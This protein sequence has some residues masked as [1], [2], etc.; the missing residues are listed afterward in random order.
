MTSAGISCPCLPFRDGDGSLE[1]LVLVIGPSSRQA[2]QAVSSLLRRTDLQSSAEELDHGLIKGSLQP[3]ALAF[4]GLGELEGRFWIVRLSIGAPLS[5][6]YSTPS[7]GLRAGW[8]LSGGDARVPVAC[9]GTR[10]MAGRPA[11]ALPSDPIYCRGPSRR[12]HF[13]EEGKPFMPSDIEIAQQAKLQ[14]IAKV[15]RRSSASPR[16]TSSP[17][18][19][20][21]P[22]SR[23]TT[24]TALKRQAGRQADPGHRDQPDAGRRGQ[25]H[26]HGRPGRRA[27]PHRQEGDDLPA[28]ALARARC[29]A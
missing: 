6:C 21:R 8:W 11:V 22:R 2:C 19:T 3:R 27:Q 5:G 29:S 4:E 18:A 7:E 9:V 1:A 15:R 20:T 13:R 28:R 24:S 17:T 12:T 26:D 23:S 10:R 25:D 16:S 14:R